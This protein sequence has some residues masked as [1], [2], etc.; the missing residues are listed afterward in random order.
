MKIAFVSVKQAILPALAMAVLFVTSTSQATAAQKMGTLSAKDAKTLTLTA[1]T[2]AD[3]LKLARHFTALAEQH[4]AEAAEHEA[5]AA[6]YTR[7]PQVSSAKHPMA[8][9][10]AEHCKYYAEHCRK[11]AAELRARARQHE[12][13]SRIAI[14]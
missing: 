4:E 14:R 7:N 6:E 13:Q 11:T 12:E 3:H 2:P 1:S 10:S 9:N 5:L 8:P